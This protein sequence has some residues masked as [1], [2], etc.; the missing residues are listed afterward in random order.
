MSTPTYNT[1]RNRGVGAWAVVGGGGGG[2]GGVARWRAGKHLYFV[3]AL[4]LSK[5]ATVCAVIKSHHVA[6]LVEA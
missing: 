3:T 1:I 2:G 6:S 4:V 5:Q